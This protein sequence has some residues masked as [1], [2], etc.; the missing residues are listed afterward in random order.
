[1]VKACK[2]F[3]QNMDK[4]FKFWYNFCNVSFFNIYRTCGLV[5]YTMLS[6]NIA[7]RGVMVRVKVDVVMMLWMTKRDRSHG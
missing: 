4:I 5:Y 2:K 3:M 7:G 1:M 6:M